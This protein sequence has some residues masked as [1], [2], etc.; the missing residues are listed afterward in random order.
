MGAEAWM[1]SQGVQL[2]VLDDPRCV[3][4]MERMIREKPDVW[5]EDIGL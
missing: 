5:A 3:A 1:R 2:T 4:L